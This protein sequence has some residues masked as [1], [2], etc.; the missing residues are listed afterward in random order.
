MIRLYTQVALAIFLGSALTLAGVRYLLNAPIDEVSLKVL[1]GHAEI[2]ADTIGNT[3]PAERR[4]KAKAL[5]KTLGYGLQLEEG[6]ANSETRVDW[7]AGSVFIVAPVP[8]TSGQI[9][10]GPIPWGQ[11][12]TFMHGILLGALAA[13]LLSLAAVFSV[14]RS[15]KAHERVARQMCD[16]DF[17][18]SAPRDPGDLLDGIGR[19]L[20]RLADRISQLLLDERDLLRTVAHEVRAPIARM[21]F[22]VEKLQGD[23]SEKGAKDCQGLQSDL[24]QVDEL[25]EELLTYVAF[26]EFDYERPELQLEEIPVLARVEHLV[27]EVTAV[28]DEIEVDVVGDSK[29]KVLAN[30]KLFDRALTNLIL[31]AMV[32]GRPRIKVDIRSLRDHVVVD[33]QDSGPGIPEDDRPKVIKPFVRLSPQKARGTGL[34][35]AIVSRIMK[36]HGGGLYILDAPDGGASIQLVWSREAPAGLAAALKEFLKSRAGS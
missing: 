5:A 21:H 7:R 16:G 18:T 10:M 3:P 36:L 15:A 19:S 27:A 14:V 13:L 31:N 24:Q 8:K 29:A 32:Y 22:R 30:L 12:S 6:G 26:D 2:L 23:I 34:G 1:S 28:D 17:R 25:L 11:T 4:K 20:N 9:L 35:L 33:V